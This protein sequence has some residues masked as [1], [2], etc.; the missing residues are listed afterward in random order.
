MMQNCSLVIAYLSFYLEKSSKY[1]QVP[2]RRTKGC[3]LDGEGK[4]DRRHMVL[5]HCVIL[6]F[7]ID[8]PHC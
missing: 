5:H 3:R 6:V 1:L 2:E 8:C 7:E 4:G